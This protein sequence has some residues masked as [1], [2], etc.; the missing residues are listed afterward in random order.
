MPPYSLAQT[1]NFTCLVLVVALI[2]LAFMWLR[3]EVAL[4]A[5]LVGLAPLLL[6]ARGMPLLSLPRFALTPFPLFLVLGALLAR[7]RVGLRVWLGCSVT[8][9]VYLT[10]EFVTGRWVA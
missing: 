2:V 8:L 7:S 3:V 10:L 9:A 4:Y 1:I 5:T 6:P